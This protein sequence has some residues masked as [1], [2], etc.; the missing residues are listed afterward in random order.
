MTVLRFL[1][2]L[3]PLARWIGIGLLLAVLIGGTVTLRSCQTARTAKIEAKLNQNQ[4]GAA[5][6][7]G[8][9]AVG[10]IGA[11]GA[12]EDDVDRITRENEREIRQAEGADVPV[13]PDV[14]SAGM[15]ALCQRAAYRGRRECLQLAP[16]P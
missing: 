6:E 15:R 16:A 14:H 2:S 1:R 3:T 12:A 8:A 13:H 10:T 7:S 11:Q 5:L 9:D 4:T